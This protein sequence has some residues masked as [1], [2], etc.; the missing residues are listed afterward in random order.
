MCI[1]DRVKTNWHGRAGGLRMIPV[2]QSRD[3]CAAMRALRCVRCDAMRCG[4]VRRG[5]VRCDAMRCDA[6]RCDAMRCGAVRC[7]AVRCGA[8]RC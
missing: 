4:A 7:G 6:M 5:A 2:W 1:R 3:A 8:V